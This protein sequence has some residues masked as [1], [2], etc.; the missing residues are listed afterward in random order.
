MK[1]LKM[2]CIADKNIGDEALDPENQEVCYMVKLETMFERVMYDLAT[3]YE[4]EA[5]RAFENA[6]YCE[7]NVREDEVVYYF[8]VDGKEREPAVGE[9]FVL[10]DM[11]YERVA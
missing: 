9:T 5:F 6:M 4:D 1:L 8:N 7:L 2:K 11:V 3:D 10:D